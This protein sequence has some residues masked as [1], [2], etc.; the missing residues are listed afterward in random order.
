VLYIPIL[1]SSIMFVHSIGLAAFAGLTAS[2]PTLKRQASIDD[3]VATE[4]QIALD[5]A[6]ANIGGT[7]NSIVSSSGA[8][9]GVVVASPSTTNPDYFYTWVRDSSLTYTMIIDELVFGNRSFQI[10]IEDFQDS[11]A[12]LQTVTNPSGSFWPA[13]LGLGEPKFYTNETRFNG[14]WGR[15]QRDGPALRATAFLNL[16]DYIIGIN[17]TNVVQT[18][19]WPL[20]LNDLKYVGQYWNQTGYDLWEEVHGSSLFTYAAQH[21]ALVQG[22]IIAERLGFPCEPCQQAPE[23]L[24]FLQNNYWNQSG[25]YLTANVNVNNAARSGINADPILSS[26]ANFDINGTCDSIGE[27]L[28][29]RSWPHTDP[30]QASNHV[31][32]RCWQRIKYSSTRSAT[33]TQ[34]TRTSKLPTP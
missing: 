21:R 2:S 30:S 29:T 5:G 31:H 14:V 4:Y 6:L 34:L 27:F 23:I 28:H 32:L 15:P 26:I 33:S 17:R 13:G 11:Q 25:N 3:F 18:I 8:L 22:S 19:F 7:N 24:C 9:P 1:H 20:I 12:V 10:T 16:A